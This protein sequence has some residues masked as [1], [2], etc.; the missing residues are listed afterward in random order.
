MTVNTF[1]PKTTPFSEWGQACQAYSLMASPNLSIKKEIMPPRTSEQKHY[2][3]KATQYFYI[4]S[5]TAFFEL[6]HKAILLHA[7]EGIEVPPKTWHCIHNQ[8]GTYLNFLLVSSPSVEFD[9]VTK[10]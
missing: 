7:G 3:Q 5:G 4:L 9:R 10:T 2:H 1:S 6:E 8:E